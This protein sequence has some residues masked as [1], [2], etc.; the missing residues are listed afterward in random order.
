MVDCW[1]WV[2]ICSIL[3]YDWLHTCI[4]CEQTFSILKGTHFNES[5]SVQK[6]KFVILVLG[7]LVIGT[8]IHQVFSHVLI[9]DPRFDTRLWCVIKHPREWLRIYEICLNIIN[10][11]HALCIN[12]S[13]GVILLVFLAKNRY[14]V[15]KKERYRVVFVSQMRQHKDLLVAPM[16]ILVCQDSVSADR[17]LHQVY[18]WRMAHLFIVVCLLSVVGTVD[19]HFSHLCLSIFCVH[20]KV[21]GTVGMSALTT[22]GKRL[23]V[24]CSGFRHAFVV[25]QT[26]KHE[27]VKC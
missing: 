22:D 20:E 4:A 25:C 17:Y 23:V 14:R 11:F 12:L 8:S 13:A 24:A 5:Q 21:Q 19:Q 16:T 15:S 1:E 10:N 7:L 26:K 18:S 27:N 3:F 9:A 6:S 2:V